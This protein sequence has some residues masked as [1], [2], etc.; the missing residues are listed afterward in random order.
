MAPP[1]GKRKAACGESTVQYGHQHTGQ[2]AISVPQGV[3]SETQT[4]KARTESLEIVVRPEADSSPPANPTEKG[5]M[6]RWQDG[7]RYSM[8][9]LLPSLNQQA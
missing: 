8:L 2:S 6:T 7:T 9:V 5:R 3:S 1:L 4:K